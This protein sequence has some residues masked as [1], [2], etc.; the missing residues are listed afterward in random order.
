MQQPPYLQTGDTI[1]ITSTAR[2]AEE[3]A[4]DQAKKVLESWGFKVVLGK[5]LFSRHHQFAGTDQERLEELQQMLH[6]PAIKAILFSRG[7]YGTTRIID[8]IDWSPLLVQPKWLCG[9]SDVTAILCHLQRLGLSGIHATMAAAFDEK[10]GRAQ[11]LESLKR[12]LMG[13][14][15]QLTVTAHPLNRYGMAS[16]KLMGGNLSLLNN[17]IATASEPDYEGAVLFMEDLDEYLYHVDR[18]LVHLK[19]AG[20]LERL[21]G[22]V[23]GQMSGMHDNAVPF[24][25]DAY[26]I[27]AEHV[28]AYHYPVAYGFPIGH[29]P[30][31]MAMPVGTQVSLEVGA[32]GVNLYQPPKHV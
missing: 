22:L 10:P 26:E 31:N 9:F 29:E 24:G 16:G 4:I 2:W 13:Q 32:T 23:V 6:N 19:R 18:M 5:H 27:I 8:S 3:A 7:G 11:S 25:K 21:A 1:G 12:L 14:P 20:R 17:L 30:L 15:L 28:A